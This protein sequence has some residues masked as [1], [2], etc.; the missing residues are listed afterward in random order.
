[1][2]ANAETDEIVNEALVV[3][4]PYVNGE[5]INGQDYGT[6]AFQVSVPA[7]VMPGR[8]KLKWQSIYRPQDGISDIADSEFMVIDPNATATV[9]GKST[10]KADDKSTGKTEQPYIPLT[11]EEIYLNTLDEWYPEGFEF[12]KSGEQECFSFLSDD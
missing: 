3:S 1:M 11:P 5:R 10:E 4:L 12:I 7:N 8:Y 2:V 6:G 9:S